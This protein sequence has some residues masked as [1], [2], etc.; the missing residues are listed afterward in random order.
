MWRFIFGIA[1][2]AAADMGHY[3]SLIRTRASK[4]GRKSMEQGLHDML[5]ET[6]LRRKRGEPGN[7]Q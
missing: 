1:Q 6:V 4:S 7:I 5:I 3:D 2:S